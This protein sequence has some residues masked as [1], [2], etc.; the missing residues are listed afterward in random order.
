MDVV[1]LLKPGAAY[2][3]EHMR[4]VVADAQEKAKVSGGA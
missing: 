3:Y 1:M 4:K 2:R